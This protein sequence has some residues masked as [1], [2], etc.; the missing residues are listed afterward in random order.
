MM[1]ILE[2][3]KQ[4]VK[5]VTK[6]ENLVDYQKFFKEKLEHRYHL[7]GPIFKK[8]SALC[9]REIESRPKKEILDICDKFLES[10]FHYGRGFAFHWALKIEKKLQKSDFV[11]LERWFKKYVDNWGSSD[12][13]S[14]GAL[15]SLINNYPELTP[16]IFKWSKSKNRWDKRASAVGLIVSLKNGKLLEEAFKTADVLLTD[17]DDMVQKGYGWMLKEASLK[18][19]DEVY[20]YIMKNKDRMPR[21]A[22][23]YALERY[24]ADKRKKAMAK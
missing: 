20:N 9:F 5:K 24:P 12:V 22:L 21:T 18:F 19:P 14:T 13:L 15:G 17:E 2:L 23:R 4:E 11:R 10:D 3:A 8:I 6:P 7:K 16:K 1:D